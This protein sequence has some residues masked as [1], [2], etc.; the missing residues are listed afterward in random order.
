MKPRWQLQAERDFLPVL[1]APDVSLDH[2]SD[3]SERVFRIVKIACDPERLAEGARVFGNLLGFYTRQIGALGTITG[4]DDGTTA[5]V[6]GIRRDADP[7]CDILV[8][9]EVA[10]EEDH[11]ALPVPPRNIFDFTEDRTMLDEK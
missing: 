3:N 11:A 8:E 2:P 5:A 1:P 9:L 7:D 4:L 10:A 6:I